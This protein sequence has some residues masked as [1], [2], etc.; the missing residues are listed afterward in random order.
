LAV[1]HNMACS[2]PQKGANSVH[3]PRGQSVTTA[4]TFKCD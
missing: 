3:E 1:L 4:R 2:V